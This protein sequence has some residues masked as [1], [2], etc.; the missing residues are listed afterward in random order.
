MLGPFPAWV[1]R[2]AGPNVDLTDIPAHQLLVEA[3]VQQDDT[4]ALRFIKGG[5]VDVHHLIRVG[6]GNDPLGY[7]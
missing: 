2:A 4:Y 5:H 6:R 3:I 1:R 7:E